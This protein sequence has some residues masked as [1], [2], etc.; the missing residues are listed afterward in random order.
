MADMILEIKTAVASEIGAKIS[1]NFVPESIVDFI[2]GP[3]QEVMKII[4]LRDGCGGDGWYAAIRVM[5]DLIW[6]VQP[7]I[8][9]SQKRQLL[10]L[11]PRLLHALR[12]GLLLIGYE[13]HEIN[14]FFNNLEK[15]HLSCIRPAPRCDSGSD[16]AAVDKVQSRQELM[17]DIAR[18]SDK[19]QAYQLDIA[20][21]VLLQSRYYQTV[22][23]MAL[24]TWL[25][26]KDRSYNKRGKLAWKCDFT[27]EFTFLDRMYNVVADISL[28]DLIELLECGNAR[29]LNDVPLLDR[30]VDA[31]VNGMKQYVRRNNGLARAMS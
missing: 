9:V 20:D 30:A 25:E 29:I 17:Q 8:V 23:T 16:P 22:N 28:R 12:E 24:G 15:I 4:G 11:I 5:D 31:V 21:P 2:Q 18:Q 14:G 1:S 27:G 7:Q 26:F 3:W 6:S 13:S 10:A 19:H